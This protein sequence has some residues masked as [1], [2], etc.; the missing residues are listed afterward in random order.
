MRNLHKI[1]ESRYR[2]SVSPAQTSLPLPPSSSSKKP[3]DVSPLSFPPRPVPLLSIVISAA[4]F[5]DFHHPLGASEGTNSVVEI[6]PIESLFTLRIAVVCGNKNGSNDSN[7][8]SSCLSI[9]TA[10]QSSRFGRSSPGTIES[11]Y[12]APSEFTVARGE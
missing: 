5:E 9:S 12:H 1:M 7:S 2:I 3:G 8:K 10:I 6:G 4:T 11:A